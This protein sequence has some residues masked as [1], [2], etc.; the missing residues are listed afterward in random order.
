MTTLQKKAK[1]RPNVL[2]VICK[3]KDGAHP[4]TALKIN[5]AII[6]SQIDNGIRIYGVAKTNLQ[7]INS[8]FNAGIRTSLR[9]VKST[10]INVLYAEAGEIPIKML[11]DI[12]KLFLMFNKRFKEKSQGP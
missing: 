6:R 8:T 10:P 5:Q 4:K 1:K 7:K 11:I 3:K 2:K 9:L 12:K